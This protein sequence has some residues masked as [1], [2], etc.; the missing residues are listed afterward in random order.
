MSARPAGLPEFANPPL[1][2]VALS[3]QFAPLAKLRSAQIGALWAAIFRRDFPRTEEHMP[4]PA[5]REEFDR[6]VAP[7][8]RVEFSDRPPVPRFWFLNEAGT[9]LVQVQQDRFTRNW[10]K[11]GE[12]DAYPRYERIREA[13][14]G[15]LAALEGFLRQEELG[16]LVIGQCEITY[17]NHVLVGDDQPVGHVAQL[18]R[19]LALLRPGCARLDSGG[20][21]DDLTVRAR[22]T[23]REAAGTPI[24]RLH[25]DAEPG[26]RRS[27]GR[28][29]VVLKLTARGK[30]EGAGIEESLRFLD[31][32]REWVGR[33]FLEVTLPEIQAFWSRP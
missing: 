13:F 11:V 21:L 20:T 4:L 28:S 22:Y 19:L 16:E 25:V 9:E 14:G 15:N 7:S 18:E 24:G 3:V 27:D 1:V 31:R 17:V 12:G 29:L 10:R 2:E 8:V 33:A 30:P 5:S 23:F 26:T 6:G 32:G